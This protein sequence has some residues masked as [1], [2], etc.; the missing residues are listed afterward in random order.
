M[1]HYIPEGTYV[2][3]GRIAYV[4]FN[5]YYWAWAGGHAVTIIGYDDN[6]TTP[7]GQGALLMV[8]SWGTDWGDNGFWKYS[9]EA[10]RTYTWYDYPYII[11]VRGLIQLPIFISYDEAFVYVPKAAKYKPR[12]MTVIGINHPYRGEVVDGIYNSTTYE[13]I[14]SSGILAGVKVNNTIVWFHNYL[15]FWIDYISDK[16][17]NAILSNLSLLESYLP[18]AHPFPESPMAF[19]VSQLSDYLV[20]YMEDKNSTPTEVTFYVQPK[21]ILPDNFTGELYNFTLLISIGGEYKVLGSLEGNVS[22][23][24]GGYVTVPLEI[25]VVSYDVAPN[26]VTVQY[27]NFNVSIYSIIPLED[28]RIVIGNESYPLTAEEGGY[29]FYANS[30][31]EKLKLHAGTYN[32]TVIVTYP[33]GKEVALPERTVTISAPTVSIISPEETIYNETVIPVKVAVKDA[34]E[35]VNV[36][37]KVGEEVLELTY[38][39]SSGYYTGTLN[40]SDGAYT[41]VVTAV[42][43]W[44]NTGVAKVH[45]IVKAGANVT[46]V[47]VENATVNVGV[48][49]NV[50]VTVEN[51]TVVA[52]VTTSEGT[53][54]VKVPVVNNVPSIFV[55]SS[56]IES[57]ATGEANATLVAGWN[58]SVEATTSVGEPEKED[59]KLLYP[60]TITADVELGENGVAVIALRDVN[61]SKI[62]LIKNGQK[63]Q[64]TTNESDPIAYYYVQ[65]GIVFVV[66]KQ[67]P[68]IVAYGSYAKPA[69]RRKVSIPTLN[70]LGYSWYKLYSEKFS[71]LYEEA[72]ELGV[73]NETLALALE[74]HQKAGE[75][76]SKVLELSEGNVIY[77]LYDIRLLAPL[78]QAYVNEMKAVRILEKAIKELKGEE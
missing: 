68:K 36:T 48:T 28:A 56:A 12:L 20:Y 63:I 76:Y 22:I 66:I 72:V 46:T 31:A 8:N 52:N 40:L 6:V 11:S 59:G 41:L 21:D 17:Y 23:P 26:N 61:I 55:N 4:N 65:N 3:S 44:N 32:Y 73:D 60:V 43:T 78:R 1:L 39:E 7:D 14:A 15:D 51:K 67:D 71:K 35:I 49:G 19:D 57:V 34:V 54:E 24:D 42:D 50:T 13:I 75:Y 77:H 53:Y 74:Y 29:Y 69:P 30:I 25:P 5:N 9:Y 70:F 47:T 16:E 33:N 10:A 18:Q 37:A 64:L 27:G 2:S 38:N 58:A 62:Y 45:F